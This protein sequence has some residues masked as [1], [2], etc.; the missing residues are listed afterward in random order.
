MSAGCLI[1]YKDGHGAKL[2]EK[3][4][5]ITENGSTTVIPNSNFNGLSKVN[6]TTNVPSISPIYQDKTISIFENTSTEVIPDSQYDALS[7]VTV[8]TDIPTYVKTNSLEEL[9]ALQN[10][11]ED[12]LGLINDTEVI[13]YSAIYQYIDGEW[14]LVGI[15]ED[16]WSSDLKTA[17]TEGHG[18]WY[19]QSML[20]Q[21]QEDSEIFKTWTQIP[22]R[23]TNSYKPYNYVPD[24]PLPSL[25]ASLFYGWT[26]IT[27]VPESFDFT[28]YASLAGLFNNCYSLKSLPISG[29]TIQ[30]TNIQFICQECRSLVGGIVI[31]APKLVW[32]DGSFKNCV[33]IT[34][35]TLNTLPLVEYLETFSGCVKL[36]T[37][38]NLN[39]SDAATYYSNLFL[40]CSALKNITFAPTASIAQSIAL[41]SSPLLTV[42]SIINVI[43][44]LKDLTGVT[45]KTLILGTT[46]L[47][48]LTDEQK[49]I[50]TNKNWVLQ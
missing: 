34:S 8:N 25:V 13:G 17:I 2:Q 31:D 15:P 44:A 42:E 41:N 21:Y 49:A 16:Q 10:V 39:I 1:L 33:N 36:E 6:I 26:K 5:E 50:A 4:V 32:M 37:V 22:A 47:N 11:K 48:K 38:N 46:N 24:L 12:T 43:N 9:N 30:A 35:I 40:D 14:I 3:N 23:T 28:Q 45:A 27:E 18:D 19:K 20:Q 29:K 7:K